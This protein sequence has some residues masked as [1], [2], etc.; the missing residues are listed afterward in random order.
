MVH[1]RISNRPLNSFSNTTNLISLHKQK[2]LALNQCLLFTILFN[3]QSFLNTGY[4][5]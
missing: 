3:P 2:T 4:H 5:P 1:K